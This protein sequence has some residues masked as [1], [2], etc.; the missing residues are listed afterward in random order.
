MTDE[1]RRRTTPVAQDAAREAAAEA[2]LEIIP[3]V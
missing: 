2:F 1:P 3:I